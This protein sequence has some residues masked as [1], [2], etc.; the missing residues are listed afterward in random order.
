MLNKAIGEQYRPGM[1]MGPYGLHWEIGDETFKD[2]GIVDGKLP[3]WVLKNEPGPS[4]RYTFTSFKHYTKDSSL[5]SSGLLGP[6][7]ILTQQK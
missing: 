4:Q 1:T 5:I 7:T 6:V 3:E 2:D